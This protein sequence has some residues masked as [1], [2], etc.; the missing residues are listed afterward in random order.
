MLSSFASSLVVISLVGVP[1]EPIAGIDDL[2]WI[3]GDWTASL[4]A[5]DAIA[6]VAAAGAPITHESS[7]RWILDNTRIQWDFKAKYNDKVFYQAKAILG[8]D[9][10][11]TLTHWWF[12]SAGD[13]DVVRWFADDGSWEVRGKLNTWRV[14]RL[15]GED[16]FVVT[17]IRLGGEPLPVKRRI[18]HERVHDSTAEPPAG[19]S[20]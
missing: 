9:E 20:D 1:A 8:P 18:V 11:G 5:R 3:I 17:Q 16:A 14:E 4:Q 6:G 7:F 10:E 13:V 19:Q 12:D 15:G 2:D